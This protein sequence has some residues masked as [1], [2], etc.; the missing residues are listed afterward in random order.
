ML[1]LIFH[2]SYMRH[3]CEEFARIR[4]KYEMGKVRLPLLSLFPSMPI[5]L[6][7]CLPPSETVLQY[8]EYF[9]LTKAV[10][11]FADKRDGNGGCSQVGIDRI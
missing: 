6:P 5:K 4:H 8:A 9:L 10:R 3:A 7:A 11:Q 1:N 2:H